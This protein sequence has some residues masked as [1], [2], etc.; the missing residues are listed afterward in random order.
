MYTRPCLKK[1][2]LRLAT[3]LT[4]TVTTD[5]DI[6]WQTCHWEG[7]K[8]LWCFVSPPHVSSASAFYLAK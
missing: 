8:S 4:Y 2:H 3:I 5:Y 1:S 6:V 7:K